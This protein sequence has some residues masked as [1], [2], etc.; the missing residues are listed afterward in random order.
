MKGSSIVASVLLAGTLAAACTA[1]TLDPSLESAL[2]R[3]SGDVRVIV[4]F[5]S[6]TTHLKMRSPADRP[7]VEQ[8]MRTPEYGAPLV[9]LGAP[10]TIDADAFK[11]AGG[12]LESKLR[13]VCEKVHAYGNVGPEERHR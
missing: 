12:D 9:V 3:S 1:G 7:A 5:P 8:A 13:M 2:S 10:L 4:T 11:T 6:R